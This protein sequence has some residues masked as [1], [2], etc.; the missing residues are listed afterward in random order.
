MVVAPL[1]LGQRVTRPEAIPE[2]AWRVGTVVGVYAQEGD[3]L[4]L[5]PLPEIYDVLWDGSKRLEG[6]YPRHGLKGL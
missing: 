2:A 6:G 5:G 1:Y 3:G 4:V